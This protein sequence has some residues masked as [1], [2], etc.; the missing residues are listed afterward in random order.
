M[1]L[2]DKIERIPSTE[3]VILYLPLDKD[4]MRDALVQDQSQEANHGT[5]TNTPVPS[6]L[7]F[8]FT[9]ASL[10][11]INCGTDASL[12][13]TSLSITAWVKLAVGYS[14]AGHVV[15][16]VSNAQPGF[17]LQIDATKKVAIN[18][19][20]TAGVAGTEVLPVD[21]WTFVGASFVGTAGKIYVNDSSPEAET[22][23]APA[24]STMPAM[25]GVR[26]NLNDSTF[27]EY[28][29]G[30]IADIR[31]YNRILTANQFLAHYNI[32]RGKYDV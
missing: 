8:L 32:Q 3:G 22:I 25:V 4:Y 5:A 23:T 20:A 30:H 13:I 6:Y 31:I 10:Q 18:G 24:S 21:E 28:F 14:A 12:D 17:F 2:I 29:D 7:G 27:K 1:R 26:T 15:A 9:A 11:R 16:K 19:G